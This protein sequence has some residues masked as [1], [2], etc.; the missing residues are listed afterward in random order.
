MP[1]SAWLAVGAV[2]GAL[3]A[4]AADPRAL[5]ILLGACAVVLGAAVTARAAWRPRL[6]A[7]AIGAAAIVVRGALAPA[8][9]GLDGAPLGSGPWRMAVEAV[10]S[11]RDG[12]QV[13]TLRSVGREGASFRLAATLPRYP[14][15]EPGDIVQVEGRTRPRPDS[16]YG[17]Y[18]ARLGA[19]GTLDARHLELIERPTDVAARF[20]R[21][22]RDAGDLL[23]R[24]LPEPEAGLAAGI[25]IGLRDRVDRDVAAAFTTAGVS[26]VVAISGWNIAIVAAA[27][28][29]LAGSLGRRRRSVVTAIAIVGYIA[30]AGASPSV[31]RAGAMAGV[32]LLARETGRSGRAAAALGWAAA[33]LLL[34]DPALV[35]D[36]GFQLSSLATAGLIAWATPL[37]DRLE[38]WSGGRLPRWLSESL[39]VSI[40]AQ[41]ATLPIVLGSFGRLALIAPDVNLLVVPLVAPAMA[42]GLLAMAGG[43]LVSAGLPDAAGAILAAPGW[44]AL[45]LM[46]RIVE[47]A[48][49]LPLASVQVE[50]A[51][52]V[53][54]AVAT[55][56]TILV[57]A[58]RSRRHRVARESSSAVRPDQPSRPIVLR[59]VTAGLVVAVAVAGAVVVLRPAGVA[60]VTVLDVGQG[61]AILVEGS[62]GGRLLVDG[63]PD[64]GR[65]LVQLDRR[66]PPWDRRLDAVILTHPHEDHVAGL[67]LLLARYR[68][69]RVLEPG[70]RGP[71]P[72]Y[73]A[74]IDRLARPGAPPHLVIAAGDRLAV[75]EIALRV[76]WPIR[77]QVPAEPPDS[78]TGIN[79][80]SVVLLGTVGPRRFL[81]AGDVEQD[82]DPSLLAEG[83]PRLDL[84]KV[85]H[86][87]SRTATTEPF[88]DAVRPRIAIASAGTGN[89]YGHPA[90]STLD[91]LAAAGA[92]VYR[93]DRDGTVTVAFEATGM[94]VRSEPRVAAGLAAPISTRGAPALPGP[95]RSFGCAVPIT[96]PLV[97]GQPTTTFPVAHQPTPG[98]QPSLG[99]HR[100][101]GATR[102]DCTAE[103]RPVA[104]RLGRRR[105]RGGTARGPVRDGPRGEAGVATRALGPPCRPRHGL[106]GRR[107]TVRATGHAGDV[108]WRDARGR[109]KPGRARPAE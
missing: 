14:E 94:T 22:R 99:Y 10:G 41:L 67:A 25:L 21:L 1:R 84:L 82:I 86:H 64:P 90:R 109:C 45:R 49:G 17:T 103:D 80:V 32:V 48:A 27:I 57:L 7:I 42:A 69:A 58:A 83:L 87:G 98:R 12:Q 51:V 105:A 26:H 93:T 34:A 60:R 16:P 75:D 8:A 89:P 13:G 50:P 54:A 65:L 68:V 33:L 97:T 20:E 71:G 36:A 4:S 2:V 35:H 23:T 91:R 74:W 59:I 5:A 73:A 63:G 61:D 24:V 66:I 15:I 92:R 72:G 85:A 30:F 43:A 37:T 77:D 6:I 100:D 31:L 38:R 107:A 96:T 19:W 3:A 88:V 81:L 95:R 18:L 56:A 46:I 29:A 101:H 76:L 44:V 11:P 9:E 53:A 52:G 70:M 47:A 79:N 40:A 78:G 55:G 28:A 62:R 108:R 106:D 102:P 104:L 39:G